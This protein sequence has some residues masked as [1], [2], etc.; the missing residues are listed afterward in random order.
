DVG[1]EVEAL[2]ADERIQASGAELANLRFEVLDAPRREGAGQDAAVQVVVGRVLEDDGTGRD[3]E[4][5]LDD[6][7]DELEH[8]ALAGDVRRP[9]DRAALD[10]LEATQGEEVVAVVV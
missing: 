2:G 1:H 3:L 9:V 10:V 5:S 8:G 7:L 6:L 4:R